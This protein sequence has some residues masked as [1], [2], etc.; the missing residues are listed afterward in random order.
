MRVERHVNYDMH[1]FPMREL[2]GVDALNLIM[3]E[4]VN[5]LFTASVAF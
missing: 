4:A 5:R 2:S 3:L 1:G